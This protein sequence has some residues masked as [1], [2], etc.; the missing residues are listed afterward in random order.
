MRYKLHG[1][2]RFYPRGINSPIQSPVHEKPLDDSRTLSRHV[3]CLGV[4]AKKRSG[5]EWYA[6]K[7]RVQFLR[8]VA[9]NRPGE[10]IRRSVVSSG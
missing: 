4:R 5:E 7:E 10:A 9:T 3:T 6:G 2:T 8:K 1:A